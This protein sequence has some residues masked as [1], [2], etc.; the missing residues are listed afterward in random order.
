MGTLLSWQLLRQVR[1]PL[2]IFEP[3]A[4]Y[5]GYS[6]FRAELEI[7]NEQ[8]EVGSCGLSGRAWKIILFCARARLEDFWVWYGFGTDRIT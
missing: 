1:S 4:G 7:E 6:D 3:Y 5:A 8:W 2:A